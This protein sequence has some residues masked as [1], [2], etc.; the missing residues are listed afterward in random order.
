MPQAGFEPGDLM[1]CLY[2]NLKH[3]NLDCSATKDS[4]PYIV[5]SSVKKSPPFPILGMSIT[6]VAK[7]YHQNISS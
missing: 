2:L 1:V 7:F 4:F 5:C 6:N 3:G